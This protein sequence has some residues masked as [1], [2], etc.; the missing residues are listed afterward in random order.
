LITIGPRYLPAH[1]VSL[2]GALETFLGPLWVWLVLDENPGIYALIGGLVVICAL[3]LH[4]VVG[5][6]L[7]NRSGPDDPA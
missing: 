1:E 2:I 7:I 6:I 4:S 3:A 5:Q